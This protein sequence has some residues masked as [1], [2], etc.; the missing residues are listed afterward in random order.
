MAKQSTSY[1]CKSC[2]YQTLKWV[3]CCPGCSEWDSFIDKNNILSTSKYSIATHKTSMISL[4]AIEI[5]PQQR[6]LSGIT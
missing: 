6:M 3:G 2:N 5:Q 4:D 1:T